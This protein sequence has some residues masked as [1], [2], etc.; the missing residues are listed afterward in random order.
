[1]NMRLSFLGPVQIEQEEVSVSNLSPGKPLALLGYIAAHIKPL[2]R[3]HLADLF[4]PNLP[5]QRGR[6]N[7]SW[8]LHKITTIMPHCLHSN[9]HSVQFKRDNACWLDIDTFQALVTQ[10]DIDSHTQAVLLY[11]GDFLEGLCLDDCADFELWLLAERERWRQ[12][13]EGVLDTLVRHHA[14]NKNY[15]E[16]L[17]YCRRLLTLAPWREETH[18]QIM[19]LLAQSGT[20][21]QGSC[22]I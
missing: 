15:D 21:R 1:M 18:Q 16:A 3:E 11:R 13:T 22:T 14:G 8:M 20:A 19:R 6:A 9:R 5:A 12:R 17:R 7:L 10:D 4:W 2:P